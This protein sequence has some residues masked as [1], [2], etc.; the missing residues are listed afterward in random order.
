M[1]AAAYAALLERQAAERAK[2]ERE[3]EESR[4]DRAL[5]RTRVEQ[6]QPKPPHPTW[7][8]PEQPSADDIYRR[9]LHNLRLEDQQ[10]L[11]GLDQRHE[12][13]RSQAQDQHPAAPTQ[14]QGKAKLSFYEDNQPSA[15]D[16]TIKR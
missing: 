10:R 11:K 6:D 12:A 9:H 14:A 1:D 2:L 15:P 5:S 4:P 7:A 16:H 8:K 13:E 3:L